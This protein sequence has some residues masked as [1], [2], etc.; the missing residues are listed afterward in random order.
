MTPNDLHFLN[1]LSVLGG[2]GI[3]GPPWTGTDRSESVRDVQDFVGPGPVR[4]LEIFLD[5]GPVRSQDSKF[6]LVLVWSGPG[7]ETFIRPGPVRDSGIRSGTNRFW[8]M[9]P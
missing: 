5:P 3:H 9:D 2:T 7:F 8:S 4:Y 6:F 1:A